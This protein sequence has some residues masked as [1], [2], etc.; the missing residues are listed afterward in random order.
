[1]PIDERWDDLS[2]EDW[3]GFAHAWVEQLRFG[4]R[5][6]QDDYGQ[7]VVMMNFTARPEQ[8]W[9]FILAAV[10]HAET[11]DE[12]GHIAAGPIEHLLGSH[13]EKFIADVESL[14]QADEKFARA[15]TGVWNY[16]MSDD[17]WA[18]VQQIQSR[19]SPLDC[20]DDS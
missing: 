14:A 2:D 8:Q 11:D 5:E 18:R 16:K 20:S 9:Q 12:L 7:S 15:L 3:T 4:V 10:E 13:G 17:V 1:M 19:A 6:G